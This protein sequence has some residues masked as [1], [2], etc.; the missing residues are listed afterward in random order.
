MKP[1]LTIVFV[2]LLTIHQVVAQKGFD[3]SQ[4]NVVWTKQSANSSESMPCGGGDIGLNVWTE[5]DEIFLYLSRSG[6]FDENNVFPKFGRVRLRI[7]PNPFQKG[8][9]KQELKLN[10]GYVEITSVKNKKKVLVKIWV[11]V[12]KPVI[13]VETESDEKLKVEAWY[14]SWRDKDLTWTQAGQI[15]ASL[16]FRDAPFQAVVRKDSVKFEGQN[17][18]WYHRNRDES[19]F[20]FTVKQ[21]K[22]DSVKSQLWN[23]L[24]N[25]TFGGWMGGD[26]FKSAG[27]SQGKYADTEF[28]AWKV[29]SKQAARKQELQIV[30]HIAG[31]ETIAQWKSGLEQI[32]QSAKNAQIADFDATKKW[33]N[34]FWQRSHIAI[35][36]SQKDSSS[37]AWQVGRNY[38][39]FRYQLG[40]NAYGTYPT[41]FNGGMFTFDPSFID[42]KFP[43]TPD[44]RDW[45]GGTHTAQ[46]QRL[47]YFPMFRSGDFDMLPSQLNFYLRALKNAEIRTKVYWG[48]NG[49]SFTEQLEQ[50][51][52][53]LATSYGWKRPQ[54]FP[55]GIE[56][57]YW[58]EYLWDTQMEFCL[59][60]LDLEKY[61]NEDISK[62]LPF[63]ESCVTFFYEHYQWEAT[64]RSKSAF[65]DDGKLI[66][67]PSTGAETYKMAYNSSST[68]AGLYSITK[69]L[70]ELSDKYL[71][72]EKTQYYEKVLKSIPEIPLK[73][74]NGYMT[75]APAEAWGRIN[76]QELPQLYPV[77]PWGMYGVGKP[78]LDI[79]INTWKY[80]AD[81]AIQKNHISWHQ[82]AIFCARLGLTEEA[83]EITVKK[84]RNAPRRY[85][86]FWGPG[87]D[88]VPDHNWGGSGMIGLQEMLLQTPDDK[89]YLFPAWPKKWDVQFKLH[90][91]ANTTIEGELKDGKVL[92]LKV[93]PEARAKD[94]ILMLK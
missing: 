24:K 68:I 17:V 94:V 54:N 77:Y 50:F 11:D 48:H 14:E 71:S 57:N 34:S 32:V 6:A 18:L 33:W 3:V 70:T 78:K 62:Y 66:L 72:S 43:F 51:G 56:H 52:L 73:E 40:C 4:Y 15:R 79:A 45:G 89:L 67:F 44:H 25:L 27:I 53:P 26:N 61:N 81:R 58:L 75:I 38:N 36:S 60:M 63:V 69:R 7:T 9:F 87:H 74:K 76:N 84:M 65:A 19:V 16:A 31:T 47:V 92:S 2:S 85:P 88:W 42:K 55:I 83:T 90:A 82:D 22:L 12:F 59:M 28:T 20:D 23:P 13:H 39:L 10:E 8:T 80:G 30:L 5:K 41:K 29:E 86:T 49:A 1:T 46:N 64:S 21:Q 91:P 93:T 37:V 35:N